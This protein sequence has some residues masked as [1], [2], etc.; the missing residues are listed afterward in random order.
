MKNSLISGVLLSFPMMA[1]AAGSPWLPAPESTSVQVSLVN[2]S[3][4]QL[5]AGDQ[6]VDLPADRDQTRFGYHFSTA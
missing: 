3:A 1:A 4:D 5:W 2:Q 6:R